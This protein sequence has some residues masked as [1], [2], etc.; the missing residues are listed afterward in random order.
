MLDIRH[1]ADGDQR[2]IVAATGQIDLATAPRLAEALTYAI[3]QGAP[4]MVLD[5]HG[6]DFLDSAG[7]RV[8]AEAARA[9]A[10]GDVSMTLEGA[11]GWVARV[12]QITGLADYLRVNPPPPPG[13]PG[14]V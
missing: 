13:G 14:E 5:L 4:E 3:D 9:A 12:L 6:V 2:A 11:Q 7:V 8:L 1:A 10:A